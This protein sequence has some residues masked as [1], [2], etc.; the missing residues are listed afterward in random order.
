VI[1]V[2][3]VTSDEWPLW[4]VLRLSALADAPFAFSSTLAEWQGPGDT[5][6][7][8]RQRL[9]TVP[10]NIVAEQHDEPVGMVSGT[11]TGDDIELIS[12]WV[13][14]EARGMGVGDALI[15][16]VVQWA[17][18][19]GAERIVLCVM[20]G[21]DAANVLY[22]RHRFVHTGQCDGQIQMARLLTL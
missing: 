20:E 7:R 2:R 17:A 10:C 3:P 19:W 21:N 15:D 13:A 1:R 6:D 9:D 8:W 4:R 11:T 5:E 12:M 18:T 14:P 22:R 16:A